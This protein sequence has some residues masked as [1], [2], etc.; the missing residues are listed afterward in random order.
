MGRDKARL[1][2]NGEVLW[3]RQVRVL[4]EAGAERVVV[5][6]GAGQRSL[7]REVE[8]VWDAVAG[9]GP[10]AGLQAALSASNARWMMVLAVDMP[11]VDAAWFRRLQ[12]VCRP[13]RGAVARRAA[14]F[15]PLAA[16]YPRE[17]LATIERQLASGRRSLQ[18]LV[19]RLVKR[20]RIRI[21]RL[22]PKD[23]WRMRNWNRPAD[24]VNEGNYGA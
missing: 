5:V 9:A 3:R 23:L 2:V 11:A 12:G 14:G 20:R 6:R 1:R 17:V 16:I 24:R 4:R 22:A 19:A 13:G 8:H 7:A 21:V 15:E 18:E 10:L